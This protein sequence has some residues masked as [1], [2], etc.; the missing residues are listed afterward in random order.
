MMA[1]CVMMPTV[2]NP[3]TP[4]AFCG[5]GKGEC[6]VSV[7]WIG[8]FVYRNAGSAVLAIGFQLPVL[9]MLSDV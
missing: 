9:R 2:K 1:V 4:P 8:K 3:L 6:I 5:W 7:L